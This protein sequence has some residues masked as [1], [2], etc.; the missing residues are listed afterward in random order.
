MLTAI[1]ML[2]PCLSASPAANASKDPLLVPRLSVPWTEATRIVGDGT[3]FHSDFCLIK[4]RR[5]RWHC[6]G[7]GGRD[8][9]DNSLFHAVGEKLTEPFV[10]RD[11]LVGE[12]GPKPDH[13]WAP[14]AIWKDED[15]ALLYY[16]HFTD[17]AEQ[18]MRVYVGEGPDLEVWKPYAGDALLR[19]NVVMEEP[20]ERDACIFWDDALDSYIMYYAAS[21]SETDERGRTGNVIRARL[22]KDLCVWSGP[23]TV[24]GPPAGYQAAESPFVLK[25]N[26]LYFLWIS[27]FDYG[28]MSLYISED[29]FD[30]GDP[31]EH[32]IEEQ[33]GH[34]P[35]I[36]TVD[37][38][39][40]MASAA[41]ASKFGNTPA[42]HDLRGVFIQA[43][44]WEPITA[45]E[46][47]KIVRK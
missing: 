29:P 3:S 25:R 33:S 1:L 9:K 34:A 37:G 26:G 6:I 18:A 10:Y 15:K 36:V 5:D 32:R 23:R 12:V 41:I 42:A 8:S 46:R 35:E 44:K 24:A 43:L 38:V 27:G 16:A 13:M 17:G 2:S 31:M 47:A 7:I 11:K 40:W 39:D 19:E 4:D 45:G 22:S 21:T 28:R 30:F 14:Y 20:A